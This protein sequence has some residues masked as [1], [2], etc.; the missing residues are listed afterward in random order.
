MNCSFPIFLNGSHTSQQAARASTLITTL[1]EGT[2]ANTT[3]LPTT[4]TTLPAS[5]TP[6]D[7]HSISPP[8]PQPEPTFTTAPQSTNTPEGNPTTDGKSAAKKT[9]RK[10]FSDSEFRLVNEHFARFIELG[11][12]P[13][14]IDCE[15]FLSCY[16]HITRSK[17]QIQDKVKNLIKYK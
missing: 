5:T 11:E 8:T 9:P 6:P 12:T 13:S 16:P 7:L 1:F 4:D 10:R 3:P 14:L 17:K 2:G 15:V